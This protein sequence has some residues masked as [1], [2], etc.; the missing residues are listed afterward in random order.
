VAVFVAIQAA[1]HE[2]PMRLSIF[3]AP[4]KKNW[5]ATSFCARCSA[6]WEKT[7]SPVKRQTMITDATPSITE[8]RPKPTSAIDDA[9]IPAV[10]A[11]APSIVIQPSD[12]HDSSFT[13]VASC[14]YRSRVSDAARGS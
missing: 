12:S 6:T 1:R 10:M 2:P 8:S 5:T 7:R 9:T 14:A 13:R 11:T 4:S 3:R